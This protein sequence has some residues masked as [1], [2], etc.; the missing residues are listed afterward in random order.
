[1]DTLS[2]CISKTVS[3]LTFDSTVCLLAFLSLPSSTDEFSKCHFFVPKPSL[4]SDVGRFLVLF[5][6]FCHIFQDSFYYSEEELCYH[7]RVSSEVY[8]CLS[9]TVISIMNHKFF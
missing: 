7:V 4:G 8:D 2:S 1:M 3:D 5:D 9:R 6:H